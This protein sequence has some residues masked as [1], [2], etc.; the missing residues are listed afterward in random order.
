[1][2]YKTIGSY[3]SYSN[4]QKILSCMVKGDIVT[5]KDLQVSTYGWAESAYSKLY[6]VDRPHS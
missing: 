4:Q 6:I 2:S 5:Y 1:M 3:N